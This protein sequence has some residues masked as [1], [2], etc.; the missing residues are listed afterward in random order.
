MV[1]IGLC[2]PSR[3]ARRP[4]DHGLPTRHA[5][6]AARV[7]LAIRQPRRTGGGGRT[8]PGSE[9]RTTIPRSTRGGRRTSDGSPQSRRRDARRQTLSPTEQ[10][11]IVLRRPALTTAR[12][13]KVLRDPAWAT[14]PGRIS[15]LAAIPRDLV[16]DAPH[17]ARPTNCPRNASFSASSGQARWDDRAGSTSDA[18]SSI[19]LLTPPRPALPEGCSPTIPR[20]PAHGAWRRVRDASAAPSPCIFGAA[21][22]LC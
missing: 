12:D 10:L 8:Q 7:I 4:S 15:S 1:W 17:R 16:A 2:H 21:A 11:A 18:T 14:L 13:C 5:L 20:P 6:P 19:R 3:A 9:Q 22:P